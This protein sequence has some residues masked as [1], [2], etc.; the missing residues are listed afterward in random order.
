MANP[1]KAGHG[2]ISCEA[3][4]LLYLGPESSFL[5][6]RRR[7]DD[8]KSPWVTPMGLYPETLEVRQMESSWEP[9]QCLGPTWA[10]PCFSSCLFPVPLR[11]SIL[12]G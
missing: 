1:A 8:P 11:L 7:W 4:L 6:I 10:L 5:P 3:L 9:E 12:V 2:H